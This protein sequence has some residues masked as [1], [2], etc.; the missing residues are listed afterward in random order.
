MPAGAEEAG[1]QF[2]AGILGLTEIEKPPD[3]AKRGGVWFALGEQGLHLGVDEEFRPARRG[4][5]AILI[6]G[7]DAFRDRLVAA[8]ISPIDD[9]SLPGYRRFYA[10]DPFGNRLEFLEK[11]AD[12]PVAFGRGRASSRPRFTE[13][14]GQY[15][16]FIDAY[17]RM[18][19]RAPAEAEMQSYFAVSPPS[20]HQMVLTL[21]RSGLIN[22]QPGVARSIRL[23]VPAEE[24]PRL[25]GV[26]DF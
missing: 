25:R 13:K 6:R 5:P 2:Y 10:A 20:V 26:D 9:D 11:T 3:L 4:H 19:R 22:R 1:R 16:A 7:L 21:E 12:K 17:I 15:L 14:Q 24:L 8:G 23:L 18:F